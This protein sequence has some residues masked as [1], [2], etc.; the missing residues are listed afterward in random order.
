MTVTAAKEFLQAM[1]NWYFI[2]LFGEVFLLRLITLVVSKMGG[3]GKQLVK[4][5]YRRKRL[6][7]KRGTK[8]GKRIRKE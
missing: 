4:E 6:W 2:E 1:W 7:D 8:R 3:G 5:K